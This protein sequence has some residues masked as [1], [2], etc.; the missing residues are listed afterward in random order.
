MLSKQKLSLFFFTKS[1]K[2]RAEYLLSGGISISGKGEKMNP[3]S[4]V[5]VVQILCTHI[6]KQKNDT[7]VTIPGVR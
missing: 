5:K 6:F 2:R 7:I 4:R 3:W 1:V